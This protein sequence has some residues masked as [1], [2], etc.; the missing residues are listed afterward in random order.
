MCLLMDGDDAESTQAGL[1][2]IS[3]ATKRYAN[4]RTRTRTRTP[5]RHVMTCILLL[6][7]LD[8]SD[9]SLGQYSDS[10]TGLDLDEMS[11]RQ[12]QCVLTLGPSDP[13]SLP[14]VVQT[15]ANPKQRSYDS[16]DNSIS[17]VLP[18][19]SCDLLR[20][21]SV[22]ET[23]FRPGIHEAT[24]NKRSDS[25]GNNC[26]DSVKPV[27]CLGGRVTAQCHCRDIDKVTQSFYCNFGSLDQAALRDSC[28]TLR[29]EK[30]EYLLRSS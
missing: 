4:T 22:S 2:S 1:P 26:V 16:W 25:R 15:L 11:H 5:K 21:C 14:R 19:Q 30:L 24:R 17:L 27:D 20:A 13:H 23:G 6:W 29:Q 9:G 28:A 12:S 10:C 18:S 7:Y 3:T 8:T